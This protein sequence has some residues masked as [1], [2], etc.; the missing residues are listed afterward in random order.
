MRTNIIPLGRVHVLIPLTAVLGMCCSPPGL[1]A[2]NNVVAWGYNIYQQTNVPPD[3][4]DAV[5]VAGGQYHSLALKA[6]GTVTAW[7]IYHDPKLGYTQMTVPSGLRNVVAIAAYGGKSLALRADG[8]LVGW[9]D[10]LSANPP[11][12]LT[13]IVAIAPGLALKADGTVVSWANNSAAPTNSPPGLTNVVAIA[14]ADEQRLALQADG[15]VVG[16][17]SWSGMGGFE[18]PLIVPAGLTDVV[19]V[20]C[21]RSLD[22]ALRPDGT[23]VAWNG[24]GVLTNLPP[25]FTNLTAI[26]AGGDYAVGLRADGTF[27]AWGRRQEVGDTDVPMEAPPGL[28]NVAAIGAGLNHGL[29]V[30]G[31]GPPFLTAP[32]VNRTVAYGGGIRIRV[33][34]SGAQ[35]LSYQWRFNGNPLPGA[36]NQMFELDNVQFT[37]AGAYSVVVSNPLG[38]A[39][40]PDVVLS[41]APNLVL[42]QPEDES[43]F[44]Y[45]HATFHVVAAARDL[46]YQWQF[47]GQD[48]PGATANPL[49]LTNL[50]WNQAG[51][52]GVVVSNQWGAARSLDANLSIGQIATW[53]AAPGTFLPLQ[54]PAGLSNVV[55]LGGGGLLALKADGTVDA[56]NTNPLNGGPLPAPLDGVTNIAAISDGSLF[57]KT[58]G[59][60]LLWQSASS[61]GPV[62]FDGLSNV[63]AVAGYGLALKADGTV[64][65]VGGA[66]P[67]PAGL[68]D[69]VAIAGGDLPIPNFNLALRSDGTVVVW[70]QDSTVNTNVPPG[71]TNVVA[72]SAVG[73]HAM[74]LRKDGTV[75]DWYWRPFRVVDVPSGL[76][77]VVSIDAGWDHSL[78]LEADGTVAAWGYD[79]FG[80]TDVPDGLRNASAIAAADYSSSALVADGPPA[81]APV[82]ANRSVVVGGTARL[83]VS[84]AGARPLSYQWRFNGADLPNATNAVLTLSN[85][86]TNQVGVYTVAVSNALGRA[87]SSDMTLSVE[88]TLIASQPQ[89]QYAFLGGIAAFSV[90]APAPGAEYQWQFNGQ[91]L[92]GATSS[93]LGLTDVQWSDA[94]QY[95]V[96][97]SDGGVSTRSDNATLSVGQV[98]AWGDSVHGTPTPIAGRKDIIAIADGDTHS[99]ALA[100]DGT[101]F[102]WG[103]NSY[104]QTTVPEGLSNVIAIAAAG[105]RSLALKNDGTVVAW[106]QGDDS[107][108][109]TLPDG[110]TDVVAIATG[111]Y[112]HSL[113][114][115]AD[116]TVAGAGTY[117]FGVPAVVPNGLSNVVAISC[118]HAHDLA[119][120]SDGTIM[121]WGADGAI[122]TNALPGVTN[123]VAIAAGQYNLALTAGGTV[124]AWGGYANTNTNRPADLT[125]IVAI[126]A[127]DTDYAALRADGTV[128]AWGD[129]LYGETNVPP[130]LT[131]A[132]AIS[133]GSTHFLALISQAPPSLHAALLGPAWNVEGFSV[134]VPTRSGHVYRLEYKDSLG[135]SAWK[136]LPLVAGNGGMRALRDATANGQARFYRV[137]EW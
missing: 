127:G 24:F 95:A 51:K 5:A 75:I 20:A 116:G 55:A 68:A 36:T 115:R 8:T 29:A 79:G 114:L 58:D 69:V 14:S 99:M 81:L 91:D 72:I 82:V 9:G 126:A 19:A 48:L 120:K 2:E 103:D 86:N 65:A 64:V 136:A 77:N 131:N 125:N 137:R 16:W 108:H 60:V 62:F 122:N 109:A 6:D 83:S 89:S 21:G 44:L 80:S 59:T 61:G 54:P 43:A 129:G 128:A 49:I 53:G 23:A 87:V 18:T 12:D 119:L 28:T 13:N 102:A 26:A 84:A 78:A 31:S 110:L 132:I 117:D 118:D 27:I 32:L 4:T 10:P 98:A 96:T 71:L 25:D 88:P 104:G 41:V 45:G 46:S 100:A 39:A 1:Q 101:V 47:N 38:Q 135:D 17:G 37:E 106:G 97:V 42:E 50:Q 35:P 123:V 15:R 34:A 70:G 134:S 7:G 94:G 124:L 76:S 112:Y 3:L 113:A 63:V 105:G 111:P 107:G 66:A 92:P 40:S 57:L 93:T 133:D 22:L 130:S 85:V 33:T 30:V 67:P 74:A 11:P 73:G 56:W 90:G 52:Y 121:E